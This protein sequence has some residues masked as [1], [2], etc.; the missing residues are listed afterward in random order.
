M[1]KKKNYFKYVVLGVVL[2]IPFIYSFFYLKAYWNPYGKGNMDNLPIAIVNQDKGEKGKDLTKQIIDSKS[3]KVNVVSSK[4]AEDGLNNKDYYAVITIPSDFTESLESVSTQNKKHPTITYSPNQKT[5]YLASQIIDRVVS[6]VEANLDNTI[7]SEIID[8]LEKN[9]NGIPNQLGQISDGF[10]TMHAGV[11]TLNTGSKKLTDGSSKLYNS[12]KEY[13]EAIRKIQSST[14]FLASSMDEFNKG[15][16]TLASSKDSLTALTMNV[17]KLANGLDQV[18]SGSNNFTQ[19]ITKYKES[20]DPTLEDTIKFAT[21]IKSLYENPNVPEEYKPSIDL[22]KDALTDLVRADALKTKFENEIEGNNKTINATLNVIN[23]QVSTLAK[24]TTKLDELTTGVATLQ[25]AA[26]D[27]A[28]GAKQLS[29]GMN[30]VSQ[31]SNTIEE[32]INELSKGNKTLNTGIE[33][34]KEKVLLSK[35]T[36]DTKIDTT[37]EDLEKTNN[38]T[39]Y[40]KQPVTVEKKEVNKVDSYGTAFSPLFISIGLWI[41]SLMLYIVLFFDKEG[42]FKTLDATSN[43]LIKRT[44]SYH[45]LATISSIILGILLSLFLD[46]SITNYFLYLVAI[47]LAANA[48]TAIMNFLIVNFKDIGK[49]VALIILVLQLAASGGTFPIETVTKGFRWLHN[50]LPMTYTINLFKECLVTIENSLLIKNLIIVICIFLVFFIINILT[51]LYRQ[52]KQG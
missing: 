46:F 39:E 28:N 21:Y 12:Y 47:V 40:S 36:L 31:Y 18:T 13:N 16:D 6:T 11:D 17:S 5:N 26:N 35:N 41:G 42:R 14:A 10:S 32:S 33:T 15:V 50:F 49:F 38:L 24:A 20:L 19:G 4:K 25:K 44:L 22:Y 51:D 1:E 3:L 7:N 48:F 52:K 23:T 9:L 34:L 8:T 29:E 45:G 37:K 30:T 43:K 27:L 2:L